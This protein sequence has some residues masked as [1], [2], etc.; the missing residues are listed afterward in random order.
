[1]IRLRDA[2]A[3]VFV[4]HALVDYVVRLINA[5]RRPGDLGMTEVASWLAYGASPRATWGSFAARALAPGPWP[6]LRRNPTTSWRS[7]LTS[8][9]TDWS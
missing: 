5:T 3:N 8:C 7:R 9:A 2:A 1:M 6:R 4:H